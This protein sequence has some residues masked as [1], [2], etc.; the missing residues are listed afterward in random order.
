MDVIVRIHSREGVG[1][2]L[3]F[4]TGQAEIERACK[5][6]RDAASRIETAEYV[7]LCSSAGSG[8]AAHAS[9]LVVLPQ[10]RGYQASSPATVRRSTK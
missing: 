6:L 2:V 9:A 7:R 5:T 4:L 3:V 1:D 8:V 10:L